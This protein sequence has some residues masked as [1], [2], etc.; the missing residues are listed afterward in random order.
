MVR[1]LLTFACKSEQVPNNINIKTLFDSGLPLI[2]ADHFQIQ[3]V[4]LNIILNAEY[5]M[6][7]AHG[8][9]TLS[10]STRKTERGISVSLADDGTGIPRENLGRVFAPFFTTKDIGKGTGLGLSICN[11][12]IDNHGGTISVKS[13]KNDGSTFTIELPV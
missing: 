10:I 12:I 4:F 3:Q 13:R 2:I 6:L 9:G 11:G 7:E 8:C 5:A 1:N